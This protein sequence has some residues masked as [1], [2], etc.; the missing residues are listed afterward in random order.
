MRR[1]EFCRSSSSTCLLLIRTVFCGS[2]PRNVYLASRRGPST[3]SRMNAVSNL[4]TMEEKIS[5]GGLLVV[6]GK[7]LSFAG[8]VAQICCP[9]AIPHGNLRCF[10]FLCHIYSFHHHFS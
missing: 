5:M 1:S 8:R 10:S 6:I 9:K 3:D 2:N 7:Y 4:S